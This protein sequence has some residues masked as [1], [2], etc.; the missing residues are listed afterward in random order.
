MIA[1]GL[2]LLPDFLLIVAGALLARL[3]VFDAAFW[4]GAERLVYFVLF[5]ALL[6]RSLAT[7]ASSIGDSLPLV[8]TGLAFTIF[9][10]VLSFLARFLFHLRR[11]EFAACFQ[12]GFR[13]NTYLALAVAERLQGPRGLAAI[14]LLVGVLV[15]VVNVAAVGVLASDRR[16]GVLPALGRNPLVLACVAGLAWAVLGWPLP[17]LPNRVLASLG[18]ASLALGLLTVGAALKL[19]V[20]GGLPLPAAAYW[21]GLKLV[22]LPA[23]AWIVGRAL[24]LQSPLLQVAVIMAAVPTAPS[25][26]VLATQMSEHGRP[27]AFLVTTGTLFAVIT[28]PL[29]L[30]ATS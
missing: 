27:V 12:C 29:W 23:C 26:Y 28:L 17:D 6:F 1:T 18:G 5:P 21:T 9:G 14:T 24:D 15:P 19:G 10:I 4:A 3:R 2:V 11:G 16:W 22:A 30:A 13:F 8:A 25:A 20:E 7:G